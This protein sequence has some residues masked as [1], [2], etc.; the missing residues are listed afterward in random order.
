[1]RFVV[2]RPRGLESAKGNL[3][4]DGLLGISGMVLVEDVW[5]LAVRGMNVVSILLDCLK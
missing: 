5:R 4:L 1:M 2:E 3:R